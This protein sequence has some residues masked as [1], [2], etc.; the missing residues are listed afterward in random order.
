MGVSNVKI[1]LARCNVQK[2]KIICIT[3]IFICK[4]NDIYKAR[5]V[6][7]EIYKMQLVIT[8]LK[9]QFSTCSFWK[10]FLTVMN[11][12]KMFLRTFDINHAFLYAALNKDLYIP[13][14]Q[15]NRVVTSLKKYSYGLRQSIYN[16]NNTLKQF[17]NAIGLHDSIYSPGLYISEDEFIMTA[18][19][20][21]NCIIAAKN[22]DKLVKYM[23]LLKTSLRWK[24]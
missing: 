5:I 3:I 24:N 12:K 23:K 22:D 14:P 10:I 15:D 20:G 1:K 16:W 17:M 21:D 11:N 2:E 6:C 18:D 13:F 7:G 19:Y 8:K 4:S 9:Y